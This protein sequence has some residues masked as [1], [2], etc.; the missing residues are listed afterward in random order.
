MRKVSIKAFSTV[1]LIFVLCILGIIFLIAIP[2]YPALTHRM[3]INTDKASAGNI[4]NAVKSWYSD[5]ST[6]T[7][8]KNKETFLEDK[9]ILTENG[10]K[11]VL[12][13]D[14]DGLEDYLDINTTPNSLVNEAKVPVPSQKFFVSLIGKDLDVRV[15]VTVGVEGIEI[16]NDSQVNYNGTANGVIYI[17]D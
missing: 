1:E 5:Y 13:S 16:N 17:E 9:K 4:A 14:I 15:V 11:S 2:I 12:L 7:V 6:D 3:K 8:L 10:R